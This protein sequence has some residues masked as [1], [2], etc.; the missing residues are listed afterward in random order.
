MLGLENFVGVIP[1]YSSSKNTDALE[2][3][4]VSEITFSSSSRIYLISDL[5]LLSTEYF[6]FL[7]LKPSF[8]R[9][10]SLVDLSRFIAN[11]VTPSSILFKKTLALFGFE[12]IFND[13]SIFFNIIGI[14]NSSVY[15]SISIFDL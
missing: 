10:I 13:L 12:D 11:G 4:V 14:S 5:L 3:M 1:I 2:G 15:F 8:F 6:T 7:S 9:I